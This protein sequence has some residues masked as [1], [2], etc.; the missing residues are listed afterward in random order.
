MLCIILSVTSDGAVVAPVKGKRSH[1]FWLPACEWS[2]DDSHWFH[3]QYLPLVGDHVSVVA[4]APGG[5][6]SGEDT[7][8]VRAP[9][10]GVGDASWLGSDCLMEVGEISKMQIRGDVR[11]VPA[12]MSKPEYLA[13]VD[14][15]GMWDAGIDHSVLVR[16]D[17]VSGMVSAVEDSSQRHLLLDSQR[18]VA[19]RKRFA[20]EHVKRARQHR[21]GVSPAASDSGPDAADEEFRPLVIPAALAEQIS[22]CLV[23]DDD[24]S[25]ETMIRQLLRRSSVG[26][27]GGRGAAASRD[28]QDPTLLDRTRFAIIDANLQPGGRDLGGM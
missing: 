24:P 4:I 25:C 26:L 8:S 23:L 16:G 7:V 2:D 14:T 13:H 18:A 11:G 28:V 5:G 3:P 17:V 20:E 12:C 10:A 21:N 9:G 1:R 19:H 15:L 22:P 27:V 6:P